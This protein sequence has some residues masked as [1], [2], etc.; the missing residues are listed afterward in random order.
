M[1]QVGEKVRIINPGILSLNV[2]HQATMT[3]VV[4]VSEDRRTLGH[5]QLQSLARPA[6]HDESSNPRTVGVVII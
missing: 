5:S 6:R 1:K 2:E 3:D 4:V